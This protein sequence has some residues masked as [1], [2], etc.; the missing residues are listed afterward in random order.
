MKDP[1][2]AAKVLKIANSSQ[3]GLTQKVNNL[4]FAASFLGVQTLR[5]IALSAAMA[6]ETPAIFRIVNPIHF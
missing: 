2:L 3:Y 1:V 5:S 6:R 4:R